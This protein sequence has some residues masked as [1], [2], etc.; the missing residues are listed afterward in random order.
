MSSS[1]AISH[2]VSISNRVTIRDSDN[3][4]IDGSKGT[5]GPIVIGDH[6]WIGL[7]VTISK[8]MPI[9]SGSVVAA[10][11]MVTSDVPE[12]TLDPCRGVPARTIRENIVWG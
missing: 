4:F 3:N 2:N 6:V 12:N 1:I 7:N 8:G 11:A 9:G 10:G 5:S